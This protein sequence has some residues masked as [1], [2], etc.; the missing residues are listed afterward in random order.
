MEDDTKRDN[1]LDKI[2]PY[3]DDHLRS[4]PASITKYAVCNGLDFKL[5]EAALQSL[6][7]FTFNCDLIPFNHLQ[8]SRAAEHRN[9][10]L[11]HSESNL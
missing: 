9:V 1:N 7:P 6:E 11:L 4:S 2:V 5:G 8:R 10:I 3:N